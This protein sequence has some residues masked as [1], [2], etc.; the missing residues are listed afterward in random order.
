MEIFKIRCNKSSTYIFSC[1]SIFIKFW[2]LKWGNY[3][4]FNR[5]LNDN[6][7]SNMTSS[8]VQNNLFH[9]WQPCNPSNTYCFNGEQY[10][11]KA[12]W[13]YCCFGQFKSNHNP[14]LLF[15]DKATHV[16]TFSW[17]IGHESFTPFQVIKAG[18]YFK[19]LPDAC[20]SHSSI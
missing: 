10:L 17:N 12:R 18:G 14:L 19:G 11:S 9:K 8:K 15:F 20:A 13:H 1:L 6:C 16:L 3:L 4:C 5:V 2:S 7:Q